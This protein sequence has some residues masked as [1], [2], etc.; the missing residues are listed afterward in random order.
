VLFKNHSTSIINIS[1]DK[2]IAQFIFEN[3]STPYLQISTSLPK[4]S[5]KGGFGS[6]DNTAAQPINAHLETE[7]TPQSPPIQST[8]SNIVF[9]PPATLLTPPASSSV[10]TATP[11]VVTMNEEMLIKSIG[12]KKTE[13]FLKHLPSLS[14]STFK[15]QQEKS[16][17]LNP[18]ETA[19][20]RSSRR[21]TTPLS[22]PDNIGD[23]WHLDIGYGPCPA[24]GGIKY[25]LLAV[26]RHS[27]YKLVYGLTNLKVSLLKAMKQFLRDCGNT[28]KLLRTD[29]DH[30]IMGGK[31]GDLLLDNK[32][33]IQ[34]SPPYRQ[35]QNGLA[36]R[37]WQEAVALARNWLTSSMLPSKFWFYA[38]KRACEIC[39]IMPTNHLPE[40]TTPFTLM[41]NKKVDY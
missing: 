34:S 12:L 1:T 24:I 16:P 30:K 40:V 15:V 4:S 35:H 21:N 33:P 9:S 22:I 7:T 5:R 20:M 26:D 25:T 17:Q 14:T 38:I 36:E 19:S 8:K 37:H 10:N 6:T 18:G 31:V 29:F 28:P 41:F 27:L 39:N 23:V 3:I 13:D 32:I 11:K 2:P